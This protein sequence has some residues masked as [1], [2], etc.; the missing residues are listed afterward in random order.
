MSPRFRCAA[1]LTLVLGVAVVAGAQQPAA[2]PP[3]APE[4]F[5]G[6]LV[7]AGGA[8]PRAQ[9]TYFT[10]KVD[11]YTTP[12]EAQD[13][14]NTLQQGGQGAVVQRLW[15]MPAAGYIKVGD[16]LGYDVQV[17]RSLPTENGRIIRV[18]TDR[19]I[20]IFEV[21]GGL[22]S[23]DYPIGLVELKLDADN[24][25]EGTL[26]AAAKVNLEGGNLE[27][28]SFGTPAFRILKVKKS[29]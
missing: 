17:I 6:R 9:A 12:E 24:K 1:A 23:E 27:L 10:L 21:R 18:L 8:V 13:L 26:I 16:R 2:P 19:P 14:L 20:Q 28:E 5:T 3:T 4:T 7:D 22:R 25:G 11:R 15:K 29:K